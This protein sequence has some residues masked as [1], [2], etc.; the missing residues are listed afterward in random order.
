MNKLICTLLICILC[1]I[2]RGGTGD[3]D[4]RIEVSF[5]GEQALVQFTIHG[6]KLKVT[7][8]SA[9]DQKLME[10]YRKALAQAQCTSEACA[11]LGSIV[12][13]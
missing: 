12:G 1:S 3:E 9:S 13:T 8:P 7:V 2:S 5:E 4:C 10:R 6:K 11:L